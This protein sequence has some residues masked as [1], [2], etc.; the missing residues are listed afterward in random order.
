MKLSKN[1][2]L[3]L[4]QYDTNWNNT[5]EWRRH[6]IF[7]QENEGDGWCYPKHRSI[8]S[9]VKTAYQ[10]KLV[11]S[12]IQGWGVLYLELLKATT[13]NESNMYA[14]KP[15]FSRAHGFESM[16]LV[17]VKPVIVIVSCRIQVVFLIWKM[18]IVLELKPFFL[19][20]S[21]WT[22]IK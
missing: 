15:H 21:L 12:C 6:V 16:V 1:H 2:N 9:I 17:L 7:I 8:H 10:K 5:R 19:W 18:L 3:K 22:L 11:V 4:L 20:L 14:T 13:Q